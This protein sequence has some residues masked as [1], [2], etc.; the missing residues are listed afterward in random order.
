MT[1]PFPCIV[2]TNLSTALQPQLRRLGAFAEHG[3][4][5]RHTVRADHERARLAMLSFPAAPDP[6]LVVHRMIG[7][8]DAGARRLG[9]IAEFLVRS[10]ISVEPF[11]AARE[12]ES[13]AARIGHCQSLALVLDRKDE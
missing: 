10:D 7:E 3:G 8:N 11:G 4:I 9:G 12:I 1:I 2:S 5:T 6:G 13:H